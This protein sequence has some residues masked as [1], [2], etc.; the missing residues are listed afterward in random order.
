MN[1]VKFKSDLTSIK[2]YDQRN[3]FVDKQIEFDQ[4]FFTTG[5]ATF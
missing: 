2:K 4:R 1:K 5:Y 3:E